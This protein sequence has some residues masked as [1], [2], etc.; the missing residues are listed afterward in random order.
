MKQ[1]DKSQEQSQAIEQKP[2][3]TLLTGLSEKEILEER[4]ASYPKF[5]SHLGMLAKADTIEDAISALKND[6]VRYW[7][8]RRFL[9]EADFHPVA[10]YDIL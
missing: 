6:I 10:H 4:R 8:N 2:Q 3:I 9:V 1:N 5:V 7:V